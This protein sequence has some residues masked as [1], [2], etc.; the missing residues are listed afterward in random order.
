MIPPSTPLKIWKFL[1]HLTF[2]IVLS[3]SALG[4]P[5]TDLLDQNFQSVDS[6]LSIIDRVFISP[7]VFHIFSSALSASQYSLFLRV[8][9]VFLPEPSPHPS[10]NLELIFLTV[11]ISF[12]LFFLQFIEAVL[13]KFEC[14]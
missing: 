4:F 7:L 13:L 5:E 1:E 2:K 11:E 6:I 12:I 8:V 14:D 10:C 9:S 3:S